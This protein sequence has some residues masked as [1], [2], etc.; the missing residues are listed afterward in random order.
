MIISNCPSHLVADSY[1]T[2]SG[3]W[4]A[5][6]STVLYICSLIYILPQDDDPFP[7]GVETTCVCVCVCVYH[8]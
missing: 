7:K 1:N 2:N 4:G 8:Y 3:L 5:L 6:E